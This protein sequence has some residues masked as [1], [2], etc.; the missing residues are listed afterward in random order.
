MIPK[1]AVKGSSA[2]YWHLVFEL[3]GTKYAL[4]VENDTVTAI[5]VSYEF[6]YVPYMRRFDCSL[7]I[8]K[9]F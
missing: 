1:E 5:E 4:H 6:D 9:L 8:N 7:K 2:N 3:E